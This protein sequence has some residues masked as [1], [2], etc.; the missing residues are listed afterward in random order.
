MAQSEQSGLGNTS[1]RPSKSRSW[2]LTLN[3]WKEEEKEELIYFFKTSTGCKWVIGDEVGENGTPHLQMYFRVKNAISFNTLKKLNPRL[4]IE[5]SRGTL[6]HNYC[7]CTKDSK[8]ESNID[9]TDTWSVNGCDGYRWPAL[10]PGALTRFLA[11]TEL[12]QLRLITLA[13]V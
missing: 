1:T 4:H 7:Y 11:L 2:S 3:N 13:T 8:Y 9:I 12:E 10:Q 5:K 6:A